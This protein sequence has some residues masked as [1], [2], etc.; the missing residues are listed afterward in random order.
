MVG[1]PLACRVRHLVPCQIFGGVLCNLWILERLA[2]HPLVIL[3]EGRDTQAHPQPTVANGP[4]LC[5]ASPTL[6]GIRAWL[7]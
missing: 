6:R 3:P 5:T 1:A 4:P 7:G 2:H